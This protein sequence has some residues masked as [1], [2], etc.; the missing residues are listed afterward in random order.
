VERTR[1]RAPLRTLQGAVALGMVRDV[2]SGRW[3]E[4]AICRGRGGEVRSERVR[5]EHSPSTSSTQRRLYQLV[6]LFPPIQSS[7]PPDTPDLLMDRRASY[8]VLA[9]ALRCLRVY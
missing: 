6:S 9:W 1:G 4:M 3:I 8:R 7:P 2:L 5:K